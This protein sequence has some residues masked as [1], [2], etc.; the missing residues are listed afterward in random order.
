M[1]ARV[2]FREELDKRGVSAY[3][4]VQETTGKV[5][6]KAVYGLASGKAKRV[7]LDTL[8]AVAEAL[9]RVSGE[10]VNVTDLLELTPAPADPTPASEQAMLNASASDLKNALAELEAGE[11]P[12]DLREWLNAFTEAAR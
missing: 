8:G 7:D 12:D 5:A 6:P 2:R 1:N 11:N 3:R 10:P 9:E 4:I